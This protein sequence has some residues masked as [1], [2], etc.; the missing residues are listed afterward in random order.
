MLT[1]M[2]FSAAVLTKIN[3]PLEIIDSIEVPALRDGQVLV[4]IAYSGVCH[5]QLME[6]QGKR[7]DDRYVPHMLGHE[8][9]GWVVDKGN[10]V[11]KVEVGEAIALGWL[12]GSGLEE[13]GTVYKSPIGNIN[14]GAV[15]TFNEYAV[16]SE[17][18]CYKLPK[19][20]G[21]DTGILL[22]CALPTGAGIVRNQIES[23]H[24]SYI[25][26]YGLGGIGLSALI[27]ASTIPHKKLIA[28]DTNQSKLELAKKLGATD[29]LLA[30]H[31][32]LHENLK[33]ITDGHL[34][35]YVIEA[36]GSCNTIETAFSLLN[37]KKG[38]CVFASHPASGEK[39]SIDPFELI[40][41]KQI[42]GSWG[43]QS[44]PDELCEFIA[45]NVSESVLTKLL[46]AP[47]RLSEINLALTALEQKKTVRG[48]IAVSDEI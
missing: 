8:A 22:G 32:Y 24:C 44:N 43:G 30:E 9:T 41:G 45:E 26:V 2:K 47:L 36:A 38:K 33:Q 46:S 3:H 4:K 19:T 20:I 28:I 14:A 35:D 39:L 34:L 25:G 37:P 29:C 48:I 27:T 42:C 10:K 13:G 16:V 12:K 15:T 23:N 11:T 21:L 6:I 5:S 7:G 31:K 1:K 18:R 17:N 40:C